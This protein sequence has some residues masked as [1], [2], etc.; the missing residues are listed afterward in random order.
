MIDL[1]L[2]NVALASIGVSVVAVVLIAVAVIAVAA[3]GRRR[4][5]D[6]GKQAQAP[7][8]GPTSV[9]TGLPVDQGTR[10]DQARREPALR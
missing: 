2:I 4:T 3:V 6:G 7:A 8:G 1:H 9:R 10:P 5:A